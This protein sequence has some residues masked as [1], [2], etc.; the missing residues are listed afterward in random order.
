MVAREDNRFESR[1]YVVTAL[2]YTGPLA[3]LDELDSNYLPFGSMKHSVPP[4]ILQVVA[5][6]VPSL[7]DTPPASLLPKFPIICA[8]SMVH[9]DS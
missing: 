9:I 8:T 1:L 6:G 2:V 4:K 7:L 5:D 3:M